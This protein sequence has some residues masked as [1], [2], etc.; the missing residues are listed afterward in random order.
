MS[1][2]DMTHLHEAARRARE[3]G[4]KAQS[5]SSRAGLSY[6]ASRMLSH[7][8]HYQKLDISPHALVSL[9]GAEEAVMKLWLKT[10]LADGEAV[11]HTDQIRTCNTTPE[12]FALFGKTMPVN[13]GVIQASRVNELREQQAR[14]R[15]GH[16]TVSDRKAEAKE[17]KRN[18][19]NKKKQSSSDE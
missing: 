6:N 17:E 7:A 4:V 11:R 18:K 8:K 1:T 5:L 13:Y 3:A 15:Q 14:R 10:C 16:K 12:F 19:G 2:R 9:L